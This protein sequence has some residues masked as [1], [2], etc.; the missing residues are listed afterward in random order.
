MA[1]ERVIIATRGKVSWDC[2]EDGIGHLG[3]PREHDGE[4]HRFVVG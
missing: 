3:L 4:L 2:L 1:V